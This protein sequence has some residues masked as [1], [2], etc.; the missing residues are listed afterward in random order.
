MRD[1]EFVRSLFSLFNELKHK[2]A[3]DLENETKS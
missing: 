1:D 2:N 3:S